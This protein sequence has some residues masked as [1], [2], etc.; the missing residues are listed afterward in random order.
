M[1]KFMSDYLPKP[2]RFLYLVVEKLI[3]MADLENAVCDVNIDNIPII[4]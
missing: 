4:Y 1:I 2:E 3:S